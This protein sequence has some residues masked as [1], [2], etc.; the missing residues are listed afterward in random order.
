[1]IGDVRGK[2]L[3]QAIEFV[4]DR[5]TRARF[6]DALAWASRWAGGRS[7]MDCCAGSTLTGSRSVRRWFRTAEQID[8]MVAVLDR[9]LGEVLAELDRNPGGRE[10]TFMRRMVPKHVRAPVRFLIY[11]RFARYLRLGIP[12]AAHCFHS[13]RLERGMDPA[14]LL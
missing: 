10:P 8:E 1:M 2:G 13:A 6:P 3:F 14:S 9:S 4:C 5:A 12:L 11:I 7:S